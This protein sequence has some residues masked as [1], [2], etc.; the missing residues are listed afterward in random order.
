M[1]ADVS[2]SPGLTKL[3]DTAGFF[4]LRQDPGRTKHYAPRVNKMTRLHCRDE[5]RKTFSLWDEVKTFA[6]DYACADR[7]LPLDAEA[8][9]WLR[10]VITLKLDGERS[11][12]KELF[13]FYR[14]ELSAMIR[15]ER[16]KNS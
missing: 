7:P 15:T 11:N 6:K 1:D 14:R 5:M 9:R 13:E 8:L 16:E 3:N 12:K 10:R 2:I 4:P